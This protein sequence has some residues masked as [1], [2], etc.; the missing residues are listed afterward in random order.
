MAIGVQ[1][2]N[3]AMNKR[4]KTVLPE[5]PESDAVLC[6]GISS[7]EPAVWAGAGTRATKAMNAIAAAL[8]TP[9]QNIVLRQPIHS[10]PNVIRLGQIAPATY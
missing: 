3:P 9:N 5:T 6:A 8:A 4:T 7:E 1:H 2:K 10:T